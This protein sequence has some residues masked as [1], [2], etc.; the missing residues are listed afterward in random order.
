M[1]FKLAFKWFGAFAL[2]IGG[3]VVFWAALVARLGA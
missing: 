3:F 1:S 2:L